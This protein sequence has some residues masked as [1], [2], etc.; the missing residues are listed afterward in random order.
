MPLAFGALCGLI[1][2]VLFA[3][4]RPDDRLTTFFGAA[5]EVGVGILIALIVERVVR[6]SDDPRVQR[7][8]AGTVTLAGLGTAAALVGLL[9]TGSTVARAAAF[10]L[11]WGGL[12]AGVTG[13]FVFVTERRMS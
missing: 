3:I 7:A 2:A 5:A 6:Q 12:G 1:A 8:S 10:T 13:L 11:T 9:I 4:L